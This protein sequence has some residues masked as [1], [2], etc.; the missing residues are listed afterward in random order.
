MKVFSRDTGETRIIGRCDVEDD[1]NLVYEVHL[2]GARSPISEAFAIG[3]ITQFDDAGGFTVQRGV[4]LLPG[5]RPEIL[6][7]WQPLTS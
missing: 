2:F 3:E 1:G 5:Q 6:P 7:G 4:L